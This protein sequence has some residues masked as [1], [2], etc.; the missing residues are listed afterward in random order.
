MVTRR[1]AFCLGLATRGATI[2]QHYYI[3]CTLGTKSDNGFAFSDTL[4][5]QH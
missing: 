4:T 2:Q 3:V 5:P 1:R